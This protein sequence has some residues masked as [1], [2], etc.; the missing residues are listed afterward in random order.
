MT[1]SPSPRFLRGTVGTVADEQIQRLQHG[2]LRDRPDAVASLAQLRGGAGKDPLTTPHL[3][4]L[5]D[6]RTLYDDGGLRREDNQ[7]R[8]E[9]AVFTAMTLWALH[10]QSRTTPMHVSGGLELGGAVRRLM[11][12][13]EVDEPV[14]RRFVRVGSAP[15]LTVLA[16]RMRELVTLLRREDI[17]L[18]YALLADQIHQWQRRETRD[19]VR[20]SW[21]R[22]FHAHPPKPTTPS[23]APRIATDETEPKDPQ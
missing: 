5:I 9:N 14:R 4:G 20:R 12:G 23:P 11:P 15:A 16:I 13:G 1:L 7:V 10:Q 22:S 17:S 19:A 2:Y 21:G 3:W 6:L 18:D 8:A